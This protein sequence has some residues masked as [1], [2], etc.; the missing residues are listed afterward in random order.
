[1]Y[2]KKDIQFSRNHD[3]DKEKAEEMRNYWH[4]F[5]VGIFKWELTSDGKRMKKGK[6]IVRV[7]GCSSLHASIYDMAENVIKQ[8]D[9][10]DW[11]GRK[12]VVVK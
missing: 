10:G 6:V 1:M 4:N 12:N 7:K 11:D 5:S 3:Y 9:A 8:L 2:N